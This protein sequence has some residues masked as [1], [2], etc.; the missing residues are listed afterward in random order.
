M[1]DFLK[2]LSKTFLFQSYS[3]KSELALKE[4]ALKQHAQ[5]GIPNP[6]TQHGNAS[7]S[8]SF[9]DIYNL[10]NTNNLKIW[11]YL[12]CILLSMCEYYVSIH[13]NFCLHLFQ[14]L[15]ADNEGLRSSVSRLQEQLDTTKSSNKAKKG[16]LE[17]LN[18]RLAQK[19]QELKD[20]QH[21][22]SSLLNS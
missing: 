17:Q 11:S 12:V 6:V 16:A 5:S 18:Q 20:I 19:I 21:E 8:I 13:S 1:T 2:V 15:L 7:H 3:S 10:Y 14:V 4:H 22:I 9:S